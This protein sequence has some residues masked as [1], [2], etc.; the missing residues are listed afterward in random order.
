MRSSGANRN[1]LTTRAYSWRIVAGFEQL[2]AI[3]DT[4]GAPVARTIEVADREIERLAAKVYRHEAIFWGVLDPEDK[5]VLTT[6]LIGLGSHS[7]TVVADANMDCRELARDFKKCFRDAGWSV[8][9]VQLTGSYWSAGASGLSALF[10]SGR[11]TLQRP[12][13]SAL[14]AAAH[15]QCTGMGGGPAPTS[16]DDRSD[17]TIIVG[18]KRMHY[19]D[20]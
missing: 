18:P 8:A 5:R 3:T 17:V 16:S 9:P 13:V 4:T 10:K 2:R 7:V 6:T 15:G 12:I 1:T 14:S 19:D 11:E 20:E